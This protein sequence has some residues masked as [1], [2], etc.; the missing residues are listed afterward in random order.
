MGTYAFVDIVSNGDKIYGKLTVNPD[1]QL[2]PGCQDTTTT[3]EEI[4]EKEDKP[5]F[6]LTI[7]VLSGIGAII[8][9]GIIIFGSK[10][11]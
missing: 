5:A 10:D 4:E 7:A 8:L 2:T 6:L 9:G 11:E 3:E 1:V